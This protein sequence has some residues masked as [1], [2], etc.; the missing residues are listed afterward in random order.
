MSLAH[1]N[2]AEISINIT[3][4]TDLADDEAFAIYRRE[5]AETRDNYDVLLEEGEHFPEP[6]GPCIFENELNL[7]FDQE[8]PL[9]FFHTPLRTEIC[10]W[11]I[12]EEADY[13]TLH[14]HPAFSSYFQNSTGIFNSIGMERILYRFRKYLYH[15]SYVDFEGRAVLFSAP[16]GGGKTTQG[17]LWEEYAGAT[18]VNGDRAVLED[19]NSAIIC[20]GLPIA[21]S[22]NVFLD[23]SMPLAA[24]FT[25]EK[26][27]ENR[28]RRLKGR[29]AV[30]AVY[31]QLTVNLWNPDFVRDAMDFAIY[32]ASTVPIYRL[33]C[34]ISRE[35][36][37]LAKEVV[38]EAFTQGGES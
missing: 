5:T 20:H 2:I 18:M 25:L 8:P 17:K 21:G 1:Y 24:I 15:C 7:V 13:K 28:I 10:A 35:A 26:A 31:S 34:T 37:E 12:L 11:D 30:F 33:S 36:V 29:E 6:S 27:G 3:A 9:H 14:Y 22:S 23:R 16:S 32:V 19:R 38:L 4:Q